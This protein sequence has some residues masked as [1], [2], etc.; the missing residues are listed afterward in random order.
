MQAWIAGFGGANPGATVNYQPVGSGGGRTQFIQGGV[1]FA[2]T[3]AYLK[4]DE[5]TKARERCGG[6]VIEVPSY[7][8]PIA[9]V[10]KLNGVNDLTLSPATIAGLFK[11]QITT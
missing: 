5:L 8:S 2:G 4:D 10:F 6:S 3:D 11:G 9:V 1:Q 7:V